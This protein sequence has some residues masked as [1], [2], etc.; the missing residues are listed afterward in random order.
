MIKIGV[1]VMFAMK[2]YR[3]LETDIAFLLIRFS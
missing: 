1:Y 2:I 3:K